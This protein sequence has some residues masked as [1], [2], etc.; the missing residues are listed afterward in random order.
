MNVNSFNI[1]GKL[2]VAIVCSD[3][4]SIHP[5]VHQRFGEVIRADSPPFLWSIKM[6]MENKDFHPAKKRKRLIAETISRLFSGE[7][8]KRKR[9]IYTRFFSNPFE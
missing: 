7:R 6:M 8:T 5:S 9:A 3:D 2:S 4:N 1:L